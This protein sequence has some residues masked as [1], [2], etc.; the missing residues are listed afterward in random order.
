MRKA[1]F[2]VAG[3]V[4]FIPAALAATSDSASR[5]PCAGLPL[6]SLLREA[7]PRSSA[8]SPKAASGYSHTAD[9]PEGP[10]CS[11]I[12]ELVTII[13]EE[14]SGFADR[15]CRLLRTELSRS[16]NMASE[17]RGGA[18]PGDSAPPSFWSCDFFAQD[19]ATTISARAV[20]FA[21]P[22]K[23]NRLLVMV[24]AW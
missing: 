6:L 10:T 14:S 5:E 15:F 8:A 7:A 4:L 16:G 24:S 11:S 3:A 2:L 19:G 13:P 20:Y 9:L 18:E 17:A 1:A 23:S 22:D 21:Q 12:S